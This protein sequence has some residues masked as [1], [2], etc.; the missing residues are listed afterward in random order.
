MS[1]KKDRKIK[2]LQKLPIW[3]AV[4]EM[5]IVELV[6]FSLTIFICAISMFG[7]VN[8][9][10]LNMVKE[11]RGAIEIVD[12]NWTSQNQSQIENQLKLY[13]ETHADINDIFILADDE[14]LTVVP[15]HKKK[16]CK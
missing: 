1:K 13:A 10:V 16:Y 2:R 9:L 8:T 6:I 15:E 7:I 11:C 12:N 4:L 14:I 5:I 3:P